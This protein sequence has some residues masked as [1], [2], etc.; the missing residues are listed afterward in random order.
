[1]GFFKKFARAVTKPIKAV[2]KPVAKVVK[3]AAPITAILNPVTLTTGL[4]QKTGAGR[5][6]VGTAN[7]ISGG[8][9]D[10][11]TNVVNIPSNL[12]AGN[13]V[14]EGLQSAT[15]FAPMAFGAPSTGFNMNFLDD[16]QKKLGDRAIGFAGDE[17]F[18]RLSPSAKAPIRSTPPSPSSPAEKIDRRKMSPLAIAGIAAGGITLLA[19]LV[20]VMKKA[21]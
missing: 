10:K 14:R 9:I 6:V 17:L 7:R 3:K 8:G 20:M 4:V 19:V 12:L 11:F 18:G 1:M 13:S 5:K 15:E 21:R 2:A 16:L